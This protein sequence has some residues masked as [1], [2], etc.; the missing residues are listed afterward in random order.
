MTLG[1]VVPCHRQEEHLPRTV[2]AL[3]RALAGHAWRGV[4]VLGGRDDDRAPRPV[5]GPSWQVLAPPAGV[6][7]TP[8]AARMLGFAAV[9][10]AWTLFVDADTEVNA[11][12]VGHALAATAA[13]PRVAGYGGR[14]EER[15][16]AG[17]LDWAG[18][19]DLNR[20]GDLERDVDLVTTPALYRRA[21]LLAEG[22]YD[23]RLGA[24]EDFELGLRLRRAGWRLRVLAGP[25]ARHWNPPR[26]SL[27]E[28]GR[29]W[30][31]GLTFGP[32]EALRLYLGRPGFG[33]LLGRQRLPLAMLGLWL[34]G[35]A[36]FAATALGAGALPLELWALAWLA[37]M[38][39]V[40]S[41][42]RSLRLAVLGVL[43]WSANGAGMLVGF[44]RRPRRLTLAAGAR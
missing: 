43:T 19:P 17:A 25:A 28:L 29:R 22:G 20:V 5:F 13:D 26:P 38:L 14:I 7:G 16:F 44:V 35:A 37:L 11:D 10:G 8:G 9:E 15:V 18:D 39:L 32:G 6:A 30:R 12:W 40:A 34:A 41:R 21:A 23:A 4:I 24:E 31:F 42:K 2:T 1:V 3:E 36:A 33:A 27:A